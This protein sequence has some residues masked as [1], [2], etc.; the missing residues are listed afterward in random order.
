MCC[1]PSSCAVH[2]ARV[3]CTQNVHT[4]SQWFRATRFSGA[5]HR[6]GASFR[7]VLLSRGRSD[8]GRGKRDLQELLTG[9][10]S[11]VLL[12]KNPLRGLNAAS[13]TDSHKR[14]RRRSGDSALRG[15]NRCMGTAVAHQDR[16]RRGTARRRHRH[17]CSRRRC[18]ARRRG[19]RANSVPCRCNLRLRVRWARGASAAVCQAACSACM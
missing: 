4:V 19:S 10:H 13:K 6:S 16:A 11:R 12:R 14:Q 2:P 15:Q 9:D 18:P 1:A 7:G 3:L 5:A 8:S 17:A